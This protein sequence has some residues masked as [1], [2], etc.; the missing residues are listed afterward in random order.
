M[1]TVSSAALTPPQPEFEMPAMNRRYV[2]LTCY[3][4]SY[5]LIA[6][7][8]YNLLLVVL[9]TVHAFITRKLPDNFNEARFISMCVYATLI[10]W[11]AFAPTYF[12]TARAY[13][14]SLLLSSAVLLNDTLA[15]MFLFW[16]KVYAVLLVSEEKQQISKAPGVSNGS[17][18]ITAD[19]RARTAVTKVSKSEAS[20]PEMSRSERSKSEVSKTESV[21]NNQSVGEQEQLHEENAGP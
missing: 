5:G 15:L 17:R 11:V 6:F 21:D 7:L 8:A 14:K 16:P 20:K 10:T 2:E 18:S 3:F 13:Y 1:I 9:C 12:T 4:P 19:S